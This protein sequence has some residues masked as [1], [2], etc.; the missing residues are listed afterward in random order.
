MDRRRFVA[1]VGGAF[2]LARYVASSGAD[3]SFPQGF[4]RI[5]VLV[6]NTRVTPFWE[7]L[8]RELGAAG[9]HDGNNLRISWLEARGHP[10][11]YP[12]L[13]AQLIR[14]RP[15]L[16]LATGSEACLA[17]KSGTTTIPIVMLGAAQPVK[18]GL[19]ASLAHPGGN[20]TGISA[21]VNPEIEGK[22]LAMLK[23]I[24]PGLSR[25]LFFGT[26]WI[27]DGP[28]GIAARQAGASLGVEMLFAEHKPAAADVGLGTIAGL[29]FDAIFVALS[30]V[31]IPDTRKIVEF[32]RKRHFLATYPFSEMADAGGLFSYGT[33]NLELARVAARYIIRILNG[34][35][36]AEIPVEQPSRFELVVNLKSARELGVVIPQSVLL[37]ADRVIE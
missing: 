24:L 6:P 17:L 21:D 15:D 13:A 7:A 9:L 23:E 12:A 14:G 18:Y 32:A 4:H 25:V 37:R 29:R 22:R 30:P 16:L 5:G 31:V 26:T 28:I 20:V 8:L 10:E 2:A 35:K 11:R 27:W 1:V 34:T 19:V 33:S 3:A 36:P